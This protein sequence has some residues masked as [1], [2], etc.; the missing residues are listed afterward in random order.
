[1]K[2]KVL[3]SFSDNVEKVIQQ[4]G[5]VFDLTEE[6][7]EEIMAANENLIKEVEGDNVS[8]DFPKHTVEDITNFQM[9]RW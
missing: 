4:E 6:R 2:A 5:T 7:F 3:I 1:M 9:V 8:P